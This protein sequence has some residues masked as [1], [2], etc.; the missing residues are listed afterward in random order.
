[1]KNTYLSLLKLSFKTLYLY[2]RICNFFFNT[3]EQLVTDKFRRLECNK[4]F[5]HAL[6]KLPVCV[7]NFRNNFV[8][9]WLIHL[10]M[11]SMTGSIYIQ[12]LLIDFRL[13]I[14][15]LFTN[16][17]I[18]E[19]LIYACISTSRFIIALLYFSFF[20]YY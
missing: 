13:Q 12:D 14:Q 18:V 7:D 4:N 20:D 2:G 17:F 16:Q 11:S 10:C 6:L 3:S 19:R 5:L 9:P 1:M 8:G 15:C